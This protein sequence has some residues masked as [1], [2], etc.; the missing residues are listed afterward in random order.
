ML[1]VDG[2]ADCVLEFENPNFYYFCN[3]KY[4]LLE[5]INQ[6]LRGNELC[7][8]VFFLHQDSVTSHKSAIIVTAAITQAGFFLVVPPSDSFKNLKNT[9]IK[10]IF[11]NF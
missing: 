2:Y 6:K 9:Y 4:S 3:I 5:A 10:T 11:V 7:K 1:L 8:G